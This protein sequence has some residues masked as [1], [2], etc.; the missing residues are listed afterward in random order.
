[1]LNIS[2]LTTRWGKGFGGVNEVNTFRGTTLFTRAD[3]I[4]ALYTT[5]ATQ[6]AVVGDLYED[7]QDAA[8][9]L[10]DIYTTYID[11][12][13]NTLV[14]MSVD[15]ST[16]PIGTDDATLLKKLIADMAAQAE[17][18]LLPTVTIGGSATFVAATAVTTE[19]GA[20]KGTG[21][22]IGSI[23]EPRTGRVKIYA[24]PETV[25]LVCG[26]DSYTGGATSG[27]E[28]FGVDGEGAVA[29]THPNWPTGSGASVEM[30]S[31][32]SENSTL[33]QNAYFNDWD[34]TN[35]NE[36]EDWTTANLTPG[37]TISRSA[38]VYV[39]DYAVALT[40]API[41]AELSQTVANLTG[42]Q[43][44]AVGLRMKRPGTITAGVITVALRDA[45]GTIL[46]DAAG[47][48]LS[49]TISLAGASGSYTLTS[50][51]FALQR[52]FPT[53]VKAS[54]KV[55]TAMAAAETVL[56]DTFE[57]QPMQSLYTGGPDIGF[58]PGS[59]GWADRDTY[60]LAV[61][62]NAG[63]TTFI[64]QIDRVY[65]IKSLELDVPVSG[66]PTVNNALI[67]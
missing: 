43:N 33:V 11:I 14:Q 2:T 36:I 59:T 41:N 26:T 6:A 20:P 55:T 34:T 39:G 25:R 47:N 62:N 16:Y 15:D 56:L 27:F 52:A 63:T 9:G 19:L 13:R 18:F 58:F 10:E 22:I 8:D 35:T 21:T 40:E 60:T 4:S 67:S 49:F 30:T 61:A 37:T 7:T 48:N 57:I 17:S 66:S 54:I 46:Q 1:M 38:D 29:T 50:A 45:S 42:A 32:T 3:S 64:R 51:A 53:T 24:V 31:A 12:V 65:D 44:Y 28:T 23:I 5:A